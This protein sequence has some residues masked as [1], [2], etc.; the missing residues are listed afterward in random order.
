MKKR[1]PLDK[2]QPNPDQPRKIFDPIKLRELAESI[3]E[4]GLEQS[5][6]V[7]PFGD[8]YQIVMGERRWRAHRILA[9]EGAL[10]ERP[11]IL[12]EVKA[13]NDNEM[14]LKAIIE[15]LQRVDLRPVEEARAFQDG[16]DR[17]WTVEQLAKDLGVQQNRIASRTALL[18]LDETIQKLVDGGGFPLGHANYLVDLPKHDQVSIVQAFSQGKLKDW[19]G[20][21]AAAQA[22]R[23][24]RDHGG[25][26]GAQPEPSKDDLAAMSRME[27]IA[28]K[29]VSAIASGFKD[30]EFTAIKSVDPNKADKLADTLA[31]ASR[32]IRS[33]ESQLRSAHARTLLM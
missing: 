28:E 21:R 23:D 14:A 26:F 5:I 6:K 15:N 13:M 20:V 12:C 29:I 18:N 4:N 17:G 22:A 2:I 3:R 25:L 16:I 24:R 32:S 33:M 11:T 9:D 27:R 30:G 10:G 7:R 31:A 19:S 1:I 8:G